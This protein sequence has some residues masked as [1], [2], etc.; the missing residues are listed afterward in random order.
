MSPVF[1]LTTL[2]FNNRYL[3]SANFFF[4]IF[5]GFFLWN[6]ASEKKKEKNTTGIELDNA[7]LISKDLF[8]RITT[9]SD[10]YLCLSVCVSVIINI[11]YI[12]AS[13]YS[14][15]RWRHFKRIKR[16]CE[17]GI[18]RTLEWLNIGMTEYRNDLIETKQK[19]SKVCVAFY[20]L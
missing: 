20:L 11:V 7:I 17:L 14:L 18:I 4:H 5:G 10:S 1:L 6:L 8:T 19:A 3:A 2:V 13:R 15:W 12:K 9:S 16:L